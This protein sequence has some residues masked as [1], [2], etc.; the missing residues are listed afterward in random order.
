MYS[1]LLLIILSILAR[2][3]GQINILETDG[4]IETQGE[5]IVSSD[6]NTFPLINSENLWSINLTNPGISF[7]F[8]TEST[9][10]YLIS[11]IQIQIFTQF[12]PNCEM[13]LEVNPSEYIVYY[14][15][16]NERR[17]INLGSYNS[18]VSGDTAT[19]NIEPVPAD[20]IIVS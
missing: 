5:R 19:V 17:I 20:R 6:V 11:S 8:D 9:F 13:E 2:I 16:A 3:N 18:T 14:Q 15:I 1:V 10:N 7:K 4:N 12:S